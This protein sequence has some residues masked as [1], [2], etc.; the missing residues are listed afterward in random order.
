M[1][2]KCTLTLTANAGIIVDI[3]GS[4][5]FIDALHHGSPGKYSSVNDLVFDR[6]CNSTEMND[7]SVLLYSHCH[8]DHFSADMTSAFLAGRNIPCIIPEKK[9]DTQILLTDDYEEYRISGLRIACFRLQHMGDPGTEPAL[10]GFMIEK[11][12]VRILVPGDCEPASAELEE[13][14]LTLGHIDIAV[15]NYP[16]AALIRGRKFLDEIM[17][18]DE[19][20]LVH[21]PFEEDD[22]NN[23]RTMIKRQVQRTGASNVRLMER[24]LQTETYIISH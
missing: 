23:V 24:P 15:L 19:V 9:L 18:P 12:G 13:I 22:A 8:P 7:P 16:W 11:D 1:E 5:A 20:L 3:N 2:S 21:I 4:A 17:R 14:L 10:Y 6:I